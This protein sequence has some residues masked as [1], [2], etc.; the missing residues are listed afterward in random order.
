MSK[1][2]FACHESG[3]AKPTTCAG[4]LLRGSEHNL[5]VRMAQIERKLILS[6]VH[7]D[8]RELFANYRCMA[9]ANGVGENEECLRQCR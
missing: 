3:T 9:I 6:E 8:G 4:F 1:H 7:E 5:S 2:V